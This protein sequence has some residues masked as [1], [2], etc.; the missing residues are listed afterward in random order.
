MGGKLALLHTVAWIINVIQELCAE[1]M[2]E[3]E[4]YN[5]V[6]ESLLR[7][8]IEVGRLTPR[9]YSAV[10]NYVT[11]AQ[12]GGADAVLVT[13]SSIS[14]CVDVVQKLTGI[15]V[16]KVD[17]AMADKAVKTGDKIGVIATLPSTLNPTAELVRERARVQ[18]KDV[19]VESILCE[20]AFDA[21][22]SGDV[23]AHDQMVRN[24]LVELAK[25]VDVVVLAQASMA[26]VV[27]QLD[28]SDR[29]VPILSSPR[30]G[31][32]RVKRV[33]EGNG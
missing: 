28:S 30:L 11:S 6:D 15:P 17:E 9:I 7:E 19:S 1:L 8:A 10:A 29:I 2:P 31:V 13:C 16:V 5:I 24:A 26:R 27:D 22:A 23:E 33:M 18:G 21:A 32:E 3:V 14:P 12:Q 4:T 25:R 20:T